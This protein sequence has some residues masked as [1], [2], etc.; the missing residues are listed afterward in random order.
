MATGSLAVILGL[1]D[2]GL[3][4]ARLAADRGLRLRVCDRRT[5]EAL[6]RSLELLPEGTES[7]LG[8][9]KPDVLDDADLLIVSP[10]VVSDHPLILEARS[11]GMEVLG[12]IEFAWR[13]RPDTPLAAVTG[14]NGKSTV[15]TLIAEMLKESGIRAVA[16][17]NLSP[18]AS[19]LVL[20]ENFDCWVLEVSS[21][22]AEIFR[23][24][25]PQVGLLLNIS[26]DHLERHRDL[27]GYLEAKARLF[28]RQEKNDLAVLNA[29]DPRV[30]GL[31]APGRRQFFSLCSE[32]DA[33]LDGDLLVID[34]HELIPASDIRISGRHNIANALAAALAA[35]EL[36]AGFEGMAEAL[37]SFE[38]LPHRHRI[39][40]EAAGVVWIDDS[41]ATNVGSTLAAIEAYPPG[42]V[43]LILGGLAKAQDF[44]VLRKAVR[45]RVGR[46]YLIGRDR[47]EIADALKG[48]TEMEDC[49]DLGEAVRRAR[50]HARQGEYII[51]A[52][53]CASYDQ[54]A[55]Y[56]KRGDHFVSLARGGGDD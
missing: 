13:Q 30:A 31:R 52:P 27:A 12:E 11:R 49:V 34:D 40:H 51:L 26:Q 45:E 47:E 32:A 20:E 19:R 22:Q 44:S 16:G 28:A 14:S 24:F 39:V 5:E 3:A 41:K 8:E 36:G 6:Q 46:I 33:R 38:G 1:G 10:G 54:Y 43:H 23:D 21:F 7:R 25:R 56:G 9:E 17:G 18:P 48:C 50:Q 15:T 35:R 29:D 53:G 55:D 37:R 42:S 4:A 2:S